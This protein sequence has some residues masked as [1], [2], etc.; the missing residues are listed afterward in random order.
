MHGT[1]AQVLF[2]E[3][4]F[5]LARV[6][7]GQRLPACELTTSLDR[8]MRRVVGRELRKLKEASS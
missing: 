6:R 7:A 2:H 1:R 3:V 5:A 8:E 4:L